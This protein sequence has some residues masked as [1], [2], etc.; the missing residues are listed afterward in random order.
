[1]NLFSPFRSS[2]LRLNAPLSPLSF[3]LPQSEE[4]PLFPLQ[5]CQSRLG[6]NISSLCAKKLSPVYSQ[7]FRGLDPCSPLPLKRKL[8]IYLECIVK[9]STFA[10][11]FKDSGP[12][13]ES[14]RESFLHGEGV[15]P[16][17]IRKKSFPKKGCKYFVRNKK[18]VTF[19]V[20]FP[21]GN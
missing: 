20:R 21:L 19:A 8:P 13:E 1:M 15:E 9:G 11:A 3:C 14:S 17:C 7:S 5:S 2:L 18:G 6:S 12:V 10:L 4:R 16:S